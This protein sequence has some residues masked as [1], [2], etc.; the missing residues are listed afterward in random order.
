MVNMTVAGLWAGWL[1]GRH[2]G[3]SEECCVETG[4]P[5]YQL[6]HDTAELDRL[7]QQGRLLATA[8]RVLLQAAGLAPG[9]RVLDLGTGSGDLAF[10]VTDIVGPAGGDPGVAERD[11]AAAPQNGDIAHDL[12]ISR[13]DQDLSCSV[14][15]S[16]R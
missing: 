12:S 15:C 7:N 9:M 4:Q 5:G 14:G 2:T 10:V 3:D 16:A 8:T 13:R 1:A 11:I 6:G